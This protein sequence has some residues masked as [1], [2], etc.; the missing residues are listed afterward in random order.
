MGSIAGAMN[1]ARCSESCHLADGT[2]THND[3]RIGIN[4]S[5]APAGAAHSEISQ[6]L[7]GDPMMPRPSFAFLL[8]S[9]PLYAADSNAA[10]T[11]TGTRSSAESTWRVGLAAIASDSPYAGEDSRVIPVPAVAYQGERFFVRGVSLG[12]T[13]IESKSLALDVIGQYRFAPFHTEDLGR[14]ELAANGI[15]IDLLDDRKG[16]LDLGVAL[17]MRLPAGEFT[18][19]LLADATNTS[20]GE[21]A[22]FQYRYPIRFGGS[23]VSPAIGVTWLSDDLAN[24]EYGTLASEVARGALSYR[25]GAV[26]MPAI[27]VSFVHPLSAQWAISGWARVT[28]LPGAITDSPLVESGV[29]TESS[30]ML[31]LAR[32]F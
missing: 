14:A 13:L 1:G 30:L 25:P 8:F 22:M 26:T 6:S 31:T 28:K 2:T 21:S 15:D 5:A 9:A 18:V 12:Y 20:S 27:S 16:G 24:Y 4:I 17:T 10:G 3:Y 23:S 19:N 29:D 7:L 32:A 11:D